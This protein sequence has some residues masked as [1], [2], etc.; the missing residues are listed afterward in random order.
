MGFCR[1]A[2]LDKTIQWGLFTLSNP[3]PRSEN[4]M[5]EITRSGPRLTLITQRW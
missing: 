5:T 2:V 1:E 3:F 4:A